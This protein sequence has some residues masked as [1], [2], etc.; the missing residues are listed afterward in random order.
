MKQ[1]VRFGV[2][3]ESDLLERFDEEICAQKYTNRSEAI[4]DL[5][6]EKLIKQELEEEK[7]SLG[8]ISLLY[9]HSQRELVNKLTEIQHEYS[10]YVL[11]AQHIHLEN[12]HCLELLAAKGKP[13][14]IRALYHALRSVKG[15]K[16]G[17]ITLTATG[18]DL[19]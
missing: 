13:K 1:V 14:Q 9:D 5:I 4:R 6:R 11:S 3:L 19:P 17:G 7:E 12:S 15:V 18:E 16:H 10:R 2:S 8:T